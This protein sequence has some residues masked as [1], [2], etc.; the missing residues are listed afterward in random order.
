MAA[1][2]A[3]NVWKI[4]DVIMA[5]LIGVIFGALFFAF[6]LPWNA[7]VSMS[8]P[9]ISFLAS[10]SITAAVGA[11]QISQQVATAATIGLWVMAGPIA[12]LIIKKPGSAL[13]GE[14]LAAIIEMA[15]GSAWGVSDLIW[16]IMQGAGT[17]IGFALTGYK[18]PMLGLWFSTITSTIISFGYNYFN[19]SYNKFPVNFTLALLVIWFVSIFIFS[20]IIIFIIYKILQKAKL[21]K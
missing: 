10:H 12:A 19:A 1:R 4:K 15:I 5:G 13:L 16:G 6:G 3:T 17:E 14:L 9:I 2:T 18:K 11:S 21:A 20:G 8:G 7:F